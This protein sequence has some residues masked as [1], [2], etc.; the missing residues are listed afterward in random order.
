MIGEADGARWRR[1]GYLPLLF[2]DAMCRRERPVCR[3]NEGG[4]EAR[5][6]F[7][8]VCQLPVPPRNRDRRRCLVLCGHGDGCRVLLERE[9]GDPS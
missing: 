1:C 6:E 8:R 2:L 9:S 7:L 3:V 4:V 5:E